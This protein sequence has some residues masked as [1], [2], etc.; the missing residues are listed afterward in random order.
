MCVYM[1]MNM[2][3]RQPPQ[4]LNPHSPPPSESPNSITLHKIT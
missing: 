1:N 4:E 2:E 3:R